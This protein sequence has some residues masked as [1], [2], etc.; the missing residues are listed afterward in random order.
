M[1]YR[2]NFGHNGQE[3]YFGLGINAKMSELQSA[4]GLSV[5]PYIDEII[6]NRKRVCDYYTQNLNFKNLSRLK[7]RSD[8]TWNYSYYPIIF[9]SERELLDIKNILSKN[10]IF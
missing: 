3:E 9:N 2:H 6:K 7:L 4:M 5:L 8:T 1:K 10:N